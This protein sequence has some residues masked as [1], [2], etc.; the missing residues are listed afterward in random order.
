MEALENW[1]VD[2]GCSGALP[3]SESL[4]L[5]CSCSDE[6]VLLPFRLKTFMEALDSCVHV[7]GHHSKGAVT[8]FTSGRLRARFWLRV[9]DL[10]TVGHSGL[11]SEGD[12]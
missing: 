11:T 2:E 4:V 5:K 12:R 6:V 10:L 3:V 9:T 7:L 8:T 1:A